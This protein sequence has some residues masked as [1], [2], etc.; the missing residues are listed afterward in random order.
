MKSAL[1]RH[2]GSAPMALEQ[3]KR[4]GFISPRSPQDS[5]AYVNA[6][7]AG[8]ERSEALARESEARQLEL[9]GMCM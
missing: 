2:K 9:A 6:H 4:Q 1:A 7:A 3:L 8:L 5:W